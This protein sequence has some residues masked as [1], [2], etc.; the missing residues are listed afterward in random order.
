MITHRPTARV[1]LADPRDRILPFRFTPP[2]PWPKEPAWHLPGLL[3]G[4]HTTGPAPLRQAH[5]N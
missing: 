2:D 5:E 3:A 4:V 1:I